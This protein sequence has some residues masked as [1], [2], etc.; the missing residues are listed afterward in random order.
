MSTY[1]FGNIPFQRMI[2]RLIVP[3][4]ESDKGICNLLFISLCDIHDQI[5]EVFS[6]FNVN[7]THHAKVQIADDVTGQDEYV[8]RVGVCMKKTMNKDLF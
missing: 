7:A 5:G 6:G 8:A 2:V 1:E 4:G 3:Y